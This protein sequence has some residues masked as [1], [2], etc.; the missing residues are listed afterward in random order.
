M[1][2]GARD[3][4]SFENSHGSDRDLRRV[5]VADSFGSPLPRRGDYLIMD[6]IMSSG[7]VMAQ[8]QSLNRC[9]VYLC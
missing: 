3:R 9:R 4:L 7:L 8:I 2:E 1:A 5:P 6:F